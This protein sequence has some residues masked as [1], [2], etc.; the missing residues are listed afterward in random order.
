[1]LNYGVD[2]NQ[3]EA[4]KRKYYEKVAADLQEQYNN[5]KK[6]E[7]D[8]YAIWDGNITS[9]NSGEHYDTFVKKVGEL[10]DTVKRKNGVFDAI[11]YLIESRIKDAKRIAGID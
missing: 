8:Y 5:I 4:D 7:R 11:A 3:K 2:N 10:A 1:M 9:G 6:S